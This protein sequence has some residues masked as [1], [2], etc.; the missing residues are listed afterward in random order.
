MNTSAS[1]I[2]RTGPGPKFVK[3]T[4]DLSDVILC[5]AEPYHINVIPV[6]PGPSSA[7]IAATVSGG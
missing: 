5:L 1:K 2:V 4:K 7:R 3:M 6:P